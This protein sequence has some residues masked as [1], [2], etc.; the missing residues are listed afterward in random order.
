MIIYCTR[1]GSPYEVSETELAREIDRN[2]NIDPLCPPCHKTI[3]E[4]KDV[5]TGGDSD[6]SS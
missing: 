4:L 6:V 2:M 3:Q 1:C 5:I